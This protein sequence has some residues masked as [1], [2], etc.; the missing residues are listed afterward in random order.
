MYALRARSGHA[1][2]RSEYASGSFYSSP[3]VAYGRVDIG[4]T[5]GELYSFVASTGRIAWTH[6][7]GSWVYAS[8]AVHAGI[9]YGVAYA[10]DVAALNARTSGLLWQRHLPWRSTSSPTVIGRLVYV[11]GHGTDTR[12]GQLWSFNPAPASRSGT[13]PTASTPPSSPP[14]TIIS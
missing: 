1:L 10:G 3:A 8:P 14:A 6:T 5:D 13:S 4:N 2:W 7:F 9:V 11:G 12:H